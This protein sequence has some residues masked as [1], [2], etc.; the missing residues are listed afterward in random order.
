MFILKNMFGR[1]SKIFIVDA[2]LF[3]KGLRKKMLFKLYFS[4]SLELF[5][6]V[7]RRDTKIIETLIYSSRKL[8]FVKISASWFL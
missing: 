4:V 6:K 2:A 1:N 3:S 5:K 8:K 7:R